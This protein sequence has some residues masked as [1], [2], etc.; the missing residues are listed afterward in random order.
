M[1]V[2]GEQFVLLNISMNALALILASRLVRLRARPGRV[3]LASVLGAAYAVVAWQS[4]AVLRAVYVLIPVAALM[5]FLAFGTKI[6]SAWVATLTGGFVLSGIADFLMAR[7]VHPAL[8]V[9]ICAVGTAVVCRLP[10]GARPGKMCRLR[11]LGAEIPALIDSGNLLVDGVTGLPVILVSYA[12]VRHVLPE[13]FDPVNLQ[14]LPKGFRLIHVRTVSGSQYMMCFHPRK[15]AVNT[16]NDWQA[17]DAVVAISGN[18]QTHALLPQAL[19]TEKE[20][21]MHATAGF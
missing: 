4:A 2:Y 19:F 10:Q 20:G 15:L 17:V 16:Q 12:L 6:F 5:A 7:Q 3:I 13:N 18:R 11:V 1:R 21:K 9:G 14:T 8:V